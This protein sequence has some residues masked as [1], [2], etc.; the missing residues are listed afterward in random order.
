MTLGPTMRGFFCDLK[1]LRSTVVHKHL[2]L[3]RCERRDEYRYLRIAIPGQDV[4]KMKNVHTINKGE[5]SPHFG[6]LSCW[7]WKEWT[8]ISLAV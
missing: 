4:V 8:C 7:E 1:D 3:S 6:F 2:L 5:V